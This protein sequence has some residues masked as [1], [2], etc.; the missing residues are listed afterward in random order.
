MSQPRIL[1]A[2]IGNVFFG[3][4]GFGVEVA[5]RLLE[6]PQPDGV[7]VVDFGIRGRDLAYALLDGYDG[8]VLVDTT[9]R[10]GVPGTLYVIEPQVDGTAG[11]PDDSHGLHPARALALASTMGGRLPVLR[12][13]GCEP[14]SVPDPDG[15]AMELSAPV[16]A[17]VDAAVAIVESLVGELGEGVIQRA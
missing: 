8:A 15:M 9:A 14:S 5:R 2:G 12:V 4:D 10:G 1:V 17:A 6:R 13:V 11:T 7:V 3:D 16:A